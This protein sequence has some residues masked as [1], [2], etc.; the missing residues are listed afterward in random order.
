MKGGDGYAHFVIANENKLFFLGEFSYD[1]FIRIQY[2]TTKEDLTAI[3]KFLKLCLQK[4]KD[5]KI[6]IPTLVGNPDYWD[7]CYKS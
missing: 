6:Q 4:L 3:T 5:P 1:R 2:G 7:A